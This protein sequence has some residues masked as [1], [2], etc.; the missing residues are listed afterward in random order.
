MRRS[1]IILLPLLAGLV[2][3]SGCGQPAT[4]GPA[5]QEKSDSNVKNP[6]PPPAGKKGPPTN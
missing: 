3:A 2:L 5:A 4:T 6:P 1:G